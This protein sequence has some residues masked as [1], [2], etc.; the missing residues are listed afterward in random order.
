MNKTSITFKIIALFI[1]II[2]SCNTIVFSFQDNRIADLCESR[3]PVN[4]SITKTSKINVNMQTLCGDVGKESVEK[5]FGDIWTERI[6]N[7]PD[8]ASLVY[9]L[10]DDSDMPDY[11]RR[12]ATAIYDLAYTKTQECARSYPDIKDIDTIVAECGFAEA[13]QS[14]FDIENL[15]TKMFI[16]NPQKRGRKQIDKTNLSIQLVSLRDGKIVVR[17]K[18][19]VGS[20]WRDLVQDK[21]YSMAI[22]TKD[23]GK[24]CYVA[25]HHNALIHA[26]E[27]EEEM[28]HEKLRNL[29][30]YN[31]DQSDHVDYGNL[32]CLADGDS[33]TMVGDCEIL[34]DSEGKQYLVREGNFF[35][36]L[37]HGGKLDRLTRVL[38]LIPSVQG[39]CN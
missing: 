33:V 24:R 17:S 30:V 3:N 28:R 8:W 31:I 27:I 4:T 34:Q 11:A 10:K 22:L 20:N 12:K 39:L 35:S 38:P 18:K 6:V 9:L 7:S 1:C 19:Q 5:V 32:H 21:K 13:L 15:L 16:E 29:V 26:I 36:W 14:L 37:F 23:T 25:L 2:F